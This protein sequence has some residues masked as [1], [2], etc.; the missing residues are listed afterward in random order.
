[1]SKRAHLELSLI[2][3]MLYMAQKS[4]PPVRGLGSDFEKVL[5]EERP[6]VN[7]PDLSLFLEECKPVFQTLALKF[8]EATWL[9][10]EGSFR[11][12]VQQLKEMKELD[13]TQVESSGGY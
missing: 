6:G 12:F 3:D 9:L 13:E 1:M 5:G 10:G 8:Q 11:E 2:L 4:H 7:L